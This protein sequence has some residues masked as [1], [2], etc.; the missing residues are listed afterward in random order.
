[1]AAFT[2][3]LIMNELAISLKI[4]RYYEQ[5]LIGQSIVDQT[6]QAIVDSFVKAP[7]LQEIKMFFCM[8]N[9]LEF[10]YEHID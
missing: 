10:R 5:L 4:W 6:L 9:I 2:E 8:Q 3:S 1:M 7:E